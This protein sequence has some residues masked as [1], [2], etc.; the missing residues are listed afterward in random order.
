MRV[1]LYTRVSTEDQAREGF[2]LEVQK[3]Y[4]KQ[5]AE[6][7]GW[8]PVCTMSDKDLYEDDGYSG[9]NMNRPAIQQLLNDSRKKKFDLIL[10]YKQDRLSRNL[11]ELLTLLDELDDLGI[12]FKSATEPFDTTTSAGKM[13]IQMLGSYAEF[14]RNRLI[15]RVFP[16][17][18]AGVKN[19]HWQGA[20]FTPYGYIHNKETKKLE[21]NHDES[22]I[23]KEIF[24]MYLKGKSTSQIAAHYYNLGTPSRTGGKFYTKFIAEIL[25]NK[26]YIGKLVWNKKK[27]QKKERTK[28]GQGKGYKVYKNDPSQIIEV[29]NTHEAII[30]HE[31]FEL[32]QRILSKNRKGKIIKFKNNIYHLSGVLRCADCGGSYRGKMVIA[33]HRTQKK[34]AWYYCSSYGTFYLKCNNKAVSADV[35]D[36]QIW[37]VIDIIS[38]NLHIL[39]EMEDTIKISVSEPEECY[40]EQLE[41][42]DKALVKN[43]EDQKELYKIHKQ[44]IMNFNIYKEEAEQL[45]EAEHKLKA[46]IKTMQ[47][48]ILE[49]Q[50]SINVIDATKDFMLRLKNTTREN[51]CD[52]SIKSFMRIIFRNVYVKDQKITK[53][54]INQP[55]KLCYEKGI[56]CQKKTKKKQ[57]IKKE[58]PQSYCVPTAAK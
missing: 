29:A 6:N 58:K 35:I 52:Y 16:G 10:V 12:G 42:K 26:V 7:F 23:V 51:N 3:K 8:T 45:C 53:M 14:E 22:K 20:R 56:Q 49:K 15:E 50:N 24:D 19:G 33:N 18:V 21:I 4:L 40:R 34:K 43:L 55:W 9:S 1:A 44:G 48:K 32:A 30:S 5:Y 13:A 36:K 31:D 11:K 39:E 28:D 37:E 27:Y 57:I 17:M 25:K 54:E 47:M 2:S 38:D 41:E 46:E